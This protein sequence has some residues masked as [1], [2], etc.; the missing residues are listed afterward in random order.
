MKSKPFQL[1][2]KRSCSGTILT[3][4]NKFSF[5]NLIIPII[6]GKI[7][8]KIKEKLFDVNY[9]I[10]KSK[11]LLD[12]AKQSIEIFIEKNERAALD[13]IKSKTKR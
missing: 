9:K 7:Q 8:L 4:I 12:T 3:S 2:L 5:K 13:F 6:K 1:L 11:S 10:T